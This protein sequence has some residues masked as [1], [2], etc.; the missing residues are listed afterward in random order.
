MQETEKPSVSLAEQSSSI[1]KAFGSV[2][3]AGREILNRRGVEQSDEI[4][5]AK[6]LT[7]ACKDLLEHRGEAS[8]LALASQISS[9]LM[10]LDT[11]QRQLFFIDLAQEFHVD[12]TAVITASVEYQGAPTDE[13][14]ALIAKAIEPRRQKLFRRINT[15]PDGTASLVKIRGHLVELLAK[16][17]EF[18]RIDTDLKHLF[19]SW[20]NKGFLE[21]RRIDWESPASV[22]EKLIAYEAVHEINGWDDLRGRLNTDRRCYAFFHPSMP[23]DP[24]VFVEIALTKGVANDISEVLSADRVLSNPTSADTV[25]FYSISN[26]HPGLAGISFG[27]FLLKHVVEELHGEFPQIKTFVT[28]SPV[29]G[30]TNW[31]QSIDMP[32]LL[33]TKGVQLLSPEH[34]SSVE[35]FIEKFFTHKA[36][37]KAKQISDE[38][39]VE[40]VLELLNSEGSYLKSAMLK[41]CAHYLVMVRQGR[42]ATDP[43]ARF[44]IGNGAS[45]HQLNWKADLSL[46]GLKQS[47]GIM[48]NYLYDRNSIEFNH[49]DY[50]DKQKIAVSKG[51]RKML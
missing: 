16:F 9:A 44:H 7:I 10:S 1:G 11:E 43:V 25:V 22:L 24:L 15:A 2:L 4:N 5:S 50:F 21:L 37:L 33:D 32:A 45:L 36:E 29:P 6:T 47:A 19:I 3:N 48:V 40:A 30:F 51:V 23:N 13:N 14:L 8:G 17:P 38:E 27:N 46:S 26:C 28:L 41:L 35:S 42:L 39:F 18:K 12:E 49:D 34:K 20:F 31:L